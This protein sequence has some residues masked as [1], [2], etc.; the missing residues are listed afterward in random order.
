MENQLTIKDIQLAHPLERVTCTRCGGSGSYSYCSAYGT[1][2][3]KC[4]GKGKT[5]TKR[6]VLA[7][8]YINSLRVKSIPALD[9]QVGDFIETS[10]LFGLSRGYREV[11]K[12]EINSGGSVSFDVKGTDIGYTYQETSKVKTLSR[13]VSEIE[14]WMAGISLQNSL[15]KAGKPSK[16]TSPEHRAWIE[17]QK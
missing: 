10:S 15:T 6:G 3:F 7:V 1:R 12:K 8:Q 13:D 17:A 9:V 14:S 16:L 5:L 11:L 2:C 4:S